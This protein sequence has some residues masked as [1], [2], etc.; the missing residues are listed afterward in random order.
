[1]GLA[2]RLWEDKRLKVIDRNLLRFAPDTR[3]RVTRYDFMSEE[4][5]AV[6]Q[7]QST[8]NPIATNEPWPPMGAG[9]K[10]PSYGRGFLLV[11]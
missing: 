8:N 1:M 3:I 4:C 11:S 5:P 9:F 7:E 10:A 6:I 2:V